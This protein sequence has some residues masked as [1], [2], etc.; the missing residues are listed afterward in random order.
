MFY[1]I[2]R[3]QK[4]QSC[5]KGQNTALNVLYLYNYADIWSKLVV[6]LFSFI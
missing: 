5:Y 1:F 2:H 3:N 4:I 6:L